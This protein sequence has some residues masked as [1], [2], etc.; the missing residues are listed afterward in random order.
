M[1]DA[2]ELEAFQSIGGVRV[3]LLPIC[4]RFYAHRQV[5]LGGAPPWSLRLCGSRCV[6]E[7]PRSDMSETAVAVECLALDGDGRG[8]RLTYGSRPSTSSASRSMATVVS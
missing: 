5:Q 6:A 4:E 3:P 7:D 1:A 8:R 2:G